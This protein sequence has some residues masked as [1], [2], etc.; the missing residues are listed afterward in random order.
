MGSASEP[1]LRDTHSPALIFLLLIIGW[2]RALWLVSSH[3]VL[4]EVGGWL[5]EDT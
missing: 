3:L 1:V 2:I 4:L 5:D